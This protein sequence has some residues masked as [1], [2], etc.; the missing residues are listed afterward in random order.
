MKCKLP[1]EQ[2]IR[3]ILVK[4]EA[5]TNQSLGCRPEK[6]PVAQLIQYGIINLNKTEGPTSHQTAD[7]VKKIL[8]VGKVGH[9]GT[10]GLLN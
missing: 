5:E 3:K 8:N 2:I 10:L 9:A 1:F 4:K 7:Y 6:R